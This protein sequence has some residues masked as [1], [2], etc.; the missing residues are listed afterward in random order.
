MFLLRICT[1]ENF[2]PTAILC[3]HESNL[4]HRKKMEDQ[5][6][7]FTGERARERTS[8]ITRERGRERARERKRA[9]E[10]RGERKRE[11]EREKLRRR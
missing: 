9:S 5:V 11:R 4:E 2:V 10:R 3:A 6:R 8:E 7:A 1:F